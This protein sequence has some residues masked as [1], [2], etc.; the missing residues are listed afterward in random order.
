MSVNSYIF[1]PDKWHGLPGRSCGLTDPWHSNRS[2]P[3]RFPLIRDSRMATQL[4]KPQPE[5]HEL[6]NEGLASNSFHCHFD[7]KQTDPQ[8]VYLGKRLITFWHARHFAK[9]KYHRFDDRLFLLIRSMCFNRKCLCV[10]MSD[11]VPDNATN[12]KQPIPKSIINYE[13]QLKSRAQKHLNIH[14]TNN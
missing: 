12:H 4:T 3:V 13:K 8:R 14:E 6:C 2:S 11:S 5:T 9:D 10:C 1:N 7:R